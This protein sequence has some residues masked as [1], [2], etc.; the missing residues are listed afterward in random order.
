MDILCPD[1]RDVEVIYTRS[2]PGFSI[3]MVVICTSNNL[4]SVILDDQLHVLVP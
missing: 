4:K 1:V 3:I 2:S